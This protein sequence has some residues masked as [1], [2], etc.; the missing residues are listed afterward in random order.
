MKK[1]FLVALMVALVS[2]PCFAQE[3]DPIVSIEGTVWSYRPLCS[4][5]FT[6]GTLLGFYKGRVYSYNIRVAECFGNPE[7]SPSTY[8]DLPGFGL[9]WYN[10]YCLQTNLPICQWRVGMLFP[11]IGRG[12]HSCVGIPCLLDT[13]TLKLIPEKSLPEDF[14]SQEE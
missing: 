5:P 9:F 12:T 3:V 4:G 11:L 8:I 10:H 1:T 7:P 2:T 14:C 13:K 6:C